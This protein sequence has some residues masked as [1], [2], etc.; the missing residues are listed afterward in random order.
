MFDTHT[1]P[2]VT[3]DGPSGSGKGTICQ[4]L[5]KELGWHLLDSGALYRIVG[6][7]AER[8]GLGFD[9]AA[10]LADLAA[11]LNVEFRPSEPGEPSAVL[12]DHEDISNEVR[13]ESSGTLASKVAIHQPVR[14]ALKSLQRSFAKAPGL[15]ADGRDMGTIVFPAAAVKIYLIASAEER[16]QRRYQQLISKGESVNL[17]ALLEDIQQRDQRDMNRSIAPLKPADDAI[18]IDSSGTAI[19]DVFSQVLSQ[20]QAR[21]QS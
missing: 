17:A 5:A 16:A 2:V 14:E 13:S 4:L 1:V 18:V 3:I 20:V 12:L 9:D 19:A 7:A 11:N 8:K 6:L 21:I 10:A 15:V